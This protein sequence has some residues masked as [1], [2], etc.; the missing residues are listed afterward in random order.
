MKKWINRFSE[1]AGLLLAFTVLVALLNN[2]DPFGLLAW[3]RQYRLSG[4]GF[5]IAGFLLQRGFAEVIRWS[6][7]TTEVPMNQ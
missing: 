4:L 6:T 5:V 2:A 1:E 3:C 7:N